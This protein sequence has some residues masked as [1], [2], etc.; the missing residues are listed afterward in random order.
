MVSDPRCRW[1][2]P[3]PTPKFVK[4]GTSAMCYQDSRGHEGSEFGVRGD[5]HQYVR[6]L[7]LS[8][9]SH[10]F[11][12]S[13]VITTLISSYSS[14]IDPAQEIARL[15]H[16]ISLLEAYVFPASRTYP[17]QHRRGSEA[18]STIVPKREAV[19]AE[20]IDKAPAIA[21]GMLGSQGQGGL[22]A[23]PTSAATHL[24]LVR[25]FLAFFRT[26]PLPNARLLI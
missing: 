18:S 6:L 22:Y 2:S 4:I 25:T 24:L 17:P 3:D 14:R 13:I 8:P 1:T 15:R 7:R 12:S 11:L 20:V 9:L 23:G 21:P 5:D 10:S 19:D 26:A 16:S